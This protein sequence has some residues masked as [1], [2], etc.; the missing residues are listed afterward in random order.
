MQNFLIGSRLKPH[1]ERITPIGQYYGKTSC[2]F[3][4]VFS[5]E[6]NILKVT[7]DWKV[8]KHIFVCGFPNL[9]NFNLHFL[10]IKLANIPKDSVLMASNKGNSPALEWIE[11]V[12]IE[13]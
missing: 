10:V 9:R 11:F 4:T 1:L 5:V 7:C 6:I 13:N 12:F 2:K 3:S 8:E